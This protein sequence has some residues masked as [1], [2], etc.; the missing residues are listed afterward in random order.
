MMAVSPPQRNQGTGS[1]VA[2]RINGGQFNA[3]IGKTLVSHHRTLL[4]CYKRLSWS[5][6]AVAEVARASELAENIAKVPNSNL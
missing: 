3:Y 2:L 5:F 4:K 6:E 1:A